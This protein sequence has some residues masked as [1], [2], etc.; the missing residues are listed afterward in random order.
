MSNTTTTKSD[1]EVDV[2]DVKD[3]KATD[4][5]QYTD[6]Q[7]YGDHRN[8]RFGNLPDNPKTPGH[9]PQPGDDSLDETNST[10]LSHDTDN[11]PDRD[12]AFVRVHNDMVGDYLRAGWHTY[13]AELPVLEGDADNRPSQEKAKDPETGKPLGDD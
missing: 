6:D 13:V 4:V 8:Q 9:L 1:A 12:K 2:A 11:L 5:G 7:L 3:T 10:L